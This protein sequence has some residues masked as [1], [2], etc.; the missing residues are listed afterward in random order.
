MRSFRRWAVSALW[1]SGEA[2]F[3]CMPCAML[4][5][6]MTVTF[7]AL[8]ARDTRSHAVLSCKITGGGAGIL[9]TDAGW[10]RGDGVARRGESGETTTLGRDAFAALGCFGAADGSTARARFFPRVTVLNPSEVPGSGLAADSNSISDS[11]SEPELE[12]AHDAI[13]AGAGVGGDIGESRIQT[14]FT[15]QGRDASDSASRMHNNAAIGATTTMLDNSRLTFATA[16]T[17]ICKNASGLNGDA[18]GTENV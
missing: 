6:W 14:V 15:T 3:I 4:R 13:D 16:A 18:I 5:A 10:G 9:R 7:C 2:V 17:I 12:S 1:S 11:E 8:Q